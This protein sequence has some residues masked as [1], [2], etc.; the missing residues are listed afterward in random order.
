M[1]PAHGCQGM[2]ITP[3]DLLE[4]AYCPYLK[5]SDKTLAPPLSLFEET[6]RQ[7]ILTA[8]Q[9]ALDRDG[10]VVPRN[11]G[12]A[13]EQL[14]WPR[15]TEAG[16]PLEEVDQMAVKAAAK[17]LDYCRY[18][19]SGPNHELVGIDVSSEVRLN[20]AVLAVKADLIKMPL[21][22]PKS[23][24]FVD[25]TR[26][27]ITRQKMAC[28]MAIWATVYAFSSLKLPVSYVCV[29]LSEESQKTK[30][31]AVFFRPGEMARIGRT[32]NYLAHGIYKGIDYQCSWR[33][34]E[35]KLC[36]KS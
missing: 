18:D 27:K 29:D 15:A 35:C 23:L 2:R 3:T 36:S 33:C 34:E 13:W 31:S 17:F 9:R 12:L 16:F 4:F 20:D 7:A 26:G 21:D 5:H 22:L 30:P 28:D 24:L 6:M 14:W 10:Y 8:E 19:I 32:L 25:F 1:G 11:I